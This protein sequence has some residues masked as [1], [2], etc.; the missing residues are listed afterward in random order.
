[1][2]VLRLVAGSA[3]GVFTW[4]AWAD[5]MRSP[6]AMRSV[7]AVGPVSV[8]IGAPLLGW[9]VSLGGAAAVYWALA[10]TPLPVLVLPSGDVDGEVRKRRRMSPARSNVVLLLALGIL[11][12]AGSSLFIF[13]GALAAD[14]IGMGAG[15]IAIGFSVNAGSGLAGARWRRRPRRGWPWILVIT[16][17][18]SSMVAV[19]T[20]VGYYLGM[21]AWGFAFWMAVP[22]ILSSIAAWSLVPDER[23]GDAQSIMAFGRVL[24]PL[25][26]GFLVGVGSFVP[27][28]VFAAVGL[29]IAALLVWLVERYREER[30]APTSS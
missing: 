14:E 5:A 9:I 6:G 1:L 20:V 18:A 21:V 12:M 16:A 24:G 15:A 29:A 13:I 7:A 23:V 11:T 26:G 28:G 30:V 8:L 27:L 3:V 10:V 19:P 25:A 4:L 2:L 17:A 22:Q